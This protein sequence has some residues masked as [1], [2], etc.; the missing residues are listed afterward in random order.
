MADKYSVQRARLRRHAEVL[1]G[2][3]PIWRD[4]V[5]VRSPDDLA[6]TGPGEEI[7]SLHRAILEQYREYCTSAAKEFEN[8]ADTLQHVAKTYGQAEAIVKDYLR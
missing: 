7:A 8:V 3:S 6:F 1:D 4:G 2:A 5:N